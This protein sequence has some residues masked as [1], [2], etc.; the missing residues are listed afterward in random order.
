M[1]KNTAFSG[2]VIF[3]SIIFSF[4]SVE[5]SCGQSIYNV[6]RLRTSIEINADWSKSQWKDIDTINVCNIL[7]EKPSFLPDVQ[8]KMM[9]DSQN[10]FII[11]RVSDRYVRC[12]NKNI[13]G[14]VWND[15]C[16]EL[17]ISPDTSLPYRYY[18]LEINCGGTPLMHYN[19]NPR[20]EVRN[21]DIEDIKNIEIA[22]SLAQIVEPEIN[23][24]VTWFLECRIPIDLFRKYS[25]VTQPEPGTFWKAN[26]YKIA[27]KTSNPHYLTWSVVN[28][29]RP[30]FH[31]PQFF[32]IIK[33][34]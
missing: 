26:F 17:F 10:I 34:E 32:G 29:N 18:N 4:I 13:N 3:L 23:E 8:A 27:D 19:I 15:S 24:P 22:H 28:S 11:F 2:L 5:I 14:P 6:K 7:G 16:V 9:Y 30:D 25:N 20:K 21:I 33:F 12:I 31:L 1:G